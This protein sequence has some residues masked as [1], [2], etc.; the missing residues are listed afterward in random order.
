MDTKV[1]SSKFP[2]GIVEQLL[3]SRI[4][5]GVSIRAKKPLTISS[6]DV[7]EVA[8]IVVK[9]GG[10]FVSGGPNSYFLILGRSRQ[11]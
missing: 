4:N 5:D 10:T 6:N 8:D 1:V 9:Q 2:P 3:F 11:S 7:R